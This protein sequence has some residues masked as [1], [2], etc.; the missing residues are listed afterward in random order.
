MAMTGSMGR[1]A[2]GDHG[3]DIPGT[4]RGDELGVMAK[5]VLVFKENMIK[6]K[7]LAAKEAEAQQQREVRAR[8]IDTLTE[9]FDQEASLVLK[10]V[11]SAATEMQ[12][13]AAQ[14]T[15]KEEETSRQAEAGAAA[16]GR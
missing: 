9:G 1:L 12:A 14:M 6:A 3:V 7:E 16:P 11:A 15:S 10:T 8:T 2:E 5:A 13:T 4:Q